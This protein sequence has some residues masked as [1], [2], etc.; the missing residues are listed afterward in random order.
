[1]GEVGAGRRGLV[2]AGLYGWTAVATGTGQTVAQATAAAYNNAAKV[3]APNMRY[4]LDVGETLI[5][6]DLQ[7]LIDWNWIVPPR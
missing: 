7:R 1:L 6:G 5:N 2:T 3:R 4:R